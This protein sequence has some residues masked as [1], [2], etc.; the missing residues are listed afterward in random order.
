MNKEHFITEL[1]IH[2]KALSHDQLTYVLQKYDLLFEERSKLGE[3]EEV[4]SKNLGNPKEL[5]YEILADF[6]IPYQQTSNQQDDWIEL[7]DDLQK[8]PFLDESQYASYQTERPHTS[9]FFVRFC[10]ISGILFLNFLFMFWVLL[11]IGLVIFS[12]WIASVALLIS[13]FFGIFALMTTS[14][15]IGLFQFFFGI[16]LLGVGLLVI[17]IVTKATSYFSR[18]LKGYVKWTYNILRRGS[19]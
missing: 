3:R 11:T 8:N 17:F 2:L 1:K 12:G 15:A 19:Y 14:G 10:Q 16:L 6:N 9:S 13:P 4:I 5:A 7:T 18:F